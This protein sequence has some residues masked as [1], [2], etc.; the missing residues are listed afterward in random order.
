MKLCKHSKH[1]PRQWNVPPGKNDNIAPRVGQVLLKRAANE[2][3][4]AKQNPTMIDQSVH[5]DNEQPQ[6]G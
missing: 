5:G 4:I 6:V 2:F 3:S 1:K